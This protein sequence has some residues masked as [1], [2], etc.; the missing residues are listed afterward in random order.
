MEKIQGTQKKYFKEKQSMAAF[1]FAV[2]ANKQTL[3]IV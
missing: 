3:R 2:A 1:L